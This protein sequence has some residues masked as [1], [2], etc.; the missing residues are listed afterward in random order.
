MNNEP[1]YNL[2]PFREIQRYWQ[3]RDVLGM[4]IVFLNLCGNV[5]GFIPLGFLLPVIC[6]E[7]RRGCSVVC[8][9]FTI[10]VLIEYLQLILQVG[11]CDVDDVILNTIGTAIGWVSYRFCNWLRRRLY[12]KKTK[13]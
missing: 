10:S 12:G 4:R 6:A 8:I 3:Y 13:V 2:I 1:R 11:S 9:G 7:M 5:I